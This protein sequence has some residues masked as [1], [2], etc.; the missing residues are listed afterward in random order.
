MSFRI[1]QVVTLLYMALLTSCKYVVTSKSVAST[2]FWSVLG[3]TARIK[4]E[5]AHGSCVCDRTHMIICIIQY[6][7][8]NYR[9]L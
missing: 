6:S 4:N 9:S 5:F 1:I 8:T 2:S 3:K 7:Y